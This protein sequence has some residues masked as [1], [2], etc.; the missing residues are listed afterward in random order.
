[1]GSIPPLSFEPI[2]RFPDARAKTRGNGLKASL[3]N[4]RHESAL[5]SGTAPQ[6]ALK[7]QSVMWLSYRVDRGKHIDR[8]VSGGWCGRPFWCACSKCSEYPRG[9]FLRSFLPLR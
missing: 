5:I 2:I 7:C 9:R 8:G 3:G 4:S 6:G 1:V